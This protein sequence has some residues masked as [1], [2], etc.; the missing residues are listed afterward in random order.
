MIR[1]SNSRAGSADTGLLE[2]VDREAKQ[3]PIL[4]SLM[5]PV[6]LLIISTR[7]LEL[8]K[9]KPVPPS[10]LVV[11]PSAYRTIGRDLQGPV[12]DIPLPISEPAI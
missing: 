7:C 10:F 8:T 2:Q 4:D 12:F 1:E 3:L 11:D 9:P 6:G 5:T